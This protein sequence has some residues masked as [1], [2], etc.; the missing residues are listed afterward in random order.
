M[1]IFVSWEGKLRIVNIQQFA[2]VSE[3]MEKIGK[4]TGPPFVYNEPF[5]V[6][7][8]FNPS[9]RVFV[10]GTE[11]G[12]NSDSRTVEEMGL[13]QNAFIHFVYRSKGGGYFLGLLSKTSSCPDPRTCDFEDHGRANLSELCN[14]QVVKNIT[15]CKEDAWLF[16]C[17][18]FGMGSYEDVIR[19]N[20]ESEYVRFADVVH[21]MYHEN[22]FL[23]WDEIA[24]EVKM[25]DFHFANAIQYY[26]EKYKRPRD[27]S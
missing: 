6:K 23:T 2:K 27:A 20:S 21:R 15:Y 24:K 7:P 18:L 26:A 16:F 11:I 12:Y 17:G 19:E 22:R 4:V 3:L 13:N 10:S 14:L 8:V 1:Q 5:W 9:V 25:H